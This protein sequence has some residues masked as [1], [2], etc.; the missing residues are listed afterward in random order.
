MPGAETTRKRRAGSARRMSPTLRNWAALARLLPPN[1]TTIV[2]IFYVLCFYRI[3][4]VYHGRGGL[5]IPRGAL[6]LKTGLTPVILY[7]NNDPP[8]VRAHGEESGIKR[9]DLTG[10]ERYLIERSW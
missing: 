10:M 9:N 5:S 7:S 8:Y 4:A 1:L 2:F 6:Y 3:L